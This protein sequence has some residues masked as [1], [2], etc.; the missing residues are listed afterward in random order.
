[1][2]LKVLCIHG[3]RQNE[4]LFREKSGGLRKLLKKQVDFV[5]L[6][7][8]HEIP[9]HINLARA[10]DDRV[11]GWWFSRP[12]KSYN[13]MDRTDIITGYQESL[14]MITDKFCKDG[15][16]DGILGF[17]QG[18]SFASLLCV[19]KT[20]PDI[21]ISFKFAIMIA[22][23]RS[24]LSP[25]IGMYESPIDCPSFH[26][27]GVSDAV[28]PSVASEDLMASFV[29]AAAYKHDGGHYIPASPQLRT[30]LLDF[31][32]PFLTV[33]HDWWKQLPLYMS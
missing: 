6:S 30:A 26:T 7:A 19:L 24:Q 20:H 14:D 21:A 16:F 4:K 9:D 13:A 11:R 28:I 1:M 2:K 3:Y 18:A 17:S 27:I 10:E 22:G 32:S 25:H 15:P 5:F 33:N 23:F 12:E 31:L 29:N 8:P